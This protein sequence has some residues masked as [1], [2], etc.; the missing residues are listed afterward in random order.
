MRI[1]K[2]SVAERKKL[3]PLLKESKNLSK[4][5][6]IT[7]DIVAV[8]RFGSSV[9]GKIK[10][11]DY[12]YFIIVKDNSMKFSI[13]TGLPAPKIMD[14]GKNQFFIMPESDGEDLLDAMLYTGRKDPDRLY[15]GKTIDIT[16]QFKALYSK[17]EQ[18]K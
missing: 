2:I 16:G 4:L 12:D 5:G 6:L 9:E 18:I 17:A 14:I 15:S 11:N 1:S 8:K 13:K 3:R 7:K 10:P